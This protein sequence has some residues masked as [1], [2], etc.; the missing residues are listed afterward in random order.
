MPSPSSIAALSRL[1][2]PGAN[3]HRNQFFDPTGAQADEQDREWAQ[4]QDVE[5]ATGLNPSGMKQKGLM[6][7][8][9]QQEGLDFTRQTHADTLRRQNAAWTGPDGMARTSPAMADLANLLE[10]QK[11]HLQTDVAL[12]P[13]AEGLKDQQS[14]ADAGRNFLQESSALHTRTRGEQLENLDL[15]YGV[16]ARAKEQATQ[17]G[18][19]DKI[20]ALN[21]ALNIA[22]TNARSADERNRLTAL[23]HLVTGEQTAHVD[24]TVGHGPQLDAALGTQ[25]PSQA[26][27]EAPAPAQPPHVGSTD[28]VRMRAPDG[29]ESDVPAHLVQHYLTMTPPAV[30]VR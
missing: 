23:Q 20:A 6:D 13:M 14:E 8:E 19:D 22:I 24:P 2:S 17:L 11:E 5:A 18:H 7:L 28:T 10:G 29:T 4:I 12:E 3:P 27:A 15:Q 21:N 26:P 25:N 9:A 1:A 30:I 16:S